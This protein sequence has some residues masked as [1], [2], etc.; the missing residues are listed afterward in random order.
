MAF[1]FGDFQVQRLE[2][3]GALGFVGL[4]LVKVGFVGL[5]PT[6]SW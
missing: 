3:D 1:G 5:L 6:R 2:V 4:G